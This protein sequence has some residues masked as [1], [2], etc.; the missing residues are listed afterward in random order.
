MEKNYKI[1]DMSVS[2]VLLLIPTHLLKNEKS[3]P[4]EDDEVWEYMTKRL[5]DGKKWENVSF[6]TCSLIYKKWEEKRVTRFARDR[7]SLEAKKSNSLWLFSSRLMTHDM[8]W[9]SVLCASNSSLS[10][11][12]SRCRYIFSWKKGLKESQDMRRVKWERCHQWSH[13]VSI[14]KTRFCA[15][16]QMIASLR[17]SLS[18]LSNLVCLSYLSALISAPLMLKQMSLVICY[19]LDLLVFLKRNE[20]HVLF[21]F[22]RYILCIYSWR[23][24]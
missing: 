22:S 21:L 15:I 6:R 11:R 14:F 20:R 13:S 19:I 2:V 7:V 9:Y 24:E 16:F 8:T 3:I 10:S 4:E 1:D 5:E 23:D 18:F 17:V 12:G